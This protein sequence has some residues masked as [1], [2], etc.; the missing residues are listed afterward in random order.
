MQLSQNFFLQEFVNSETA[1]KLGIDNTPNAMQIECMKALCDIVLEPLRSHF[2]SPIRIL[3]GFRCQA[4]NSALLGAPNS[5]HTLGEAA[6]I[7]V[8]GVKNSD[9]WMFI[10]LNL[11][12]DQVIAEKLREDDGAVGWIHVSHKNYGKQRGEAISY[13]GQ[14]KYVKGLE[15]VS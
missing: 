7:S 1:E 6:D 3:S 15:Y 4:L 10:S 8:R 5:Q 11:N 13:L 2:N 14:G 12:F 9:V